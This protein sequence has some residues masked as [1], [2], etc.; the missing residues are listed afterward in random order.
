M[1]VWTRLLRV[2]V[3]TN[4]AVRDPNHKSKLIN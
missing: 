1:E 2:P 4:M 3:D